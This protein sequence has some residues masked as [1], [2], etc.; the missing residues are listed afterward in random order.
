MIVV[1]NSSPI[2]YLLL[3]G[4]LDVL[5]ALFGRVILPQAVCNELGD[6]G[7]PAMVRDWIAQPPAWIEIQPI[8]TEPDTEL[9]KLHPGEYEAIVLA[10]RL[11]ADLVIL[12]DKAAR[13]IAAKRGLNVT[14]LLGILGES[15]TRGLIDL[16]TAVDHLRK[17]TFRASPS[18]LKS[19]LNRHQ[20]T[21]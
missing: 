1:A 19:L 21:T 16:P 6:E 11:G 9:N 14:G 13:Q 20:G 3:I 2:C 8:V 12:D 5:Q 10:E 15:A 17:T 7:A 18:L 4:C